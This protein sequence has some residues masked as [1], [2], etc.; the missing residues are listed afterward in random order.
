MDDL[1][2]PATFYGY[3]FLIIMPFLE[4]LFFKNL[5]I[6]K[7]VPIK[8]DGAKTGQPDHI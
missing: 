5:I 1:Y 7:D 6:K 8:W 2:Q 4:L 3:G